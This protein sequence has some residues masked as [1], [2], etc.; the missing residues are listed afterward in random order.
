MN[1]E[2]G[3]IVY[4]SM[5]I[6]SGR[7]YSRVERCVHADTREPVVVKTVPLKEDQELFSKI[8]EVENTLRRLNSRY[9]MT[10]K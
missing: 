4:R 6:L 10:A 7:A 9:I 1:V 8:I 2:P 3:N 5:T